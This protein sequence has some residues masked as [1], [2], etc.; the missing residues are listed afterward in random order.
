M[1]KSDKQ[2]QSDNLWE[3]V[4][5]LDSSAA[6]Q[7]KQK[8]YESFPPQKIDEFEHYTI[9]EEL[10]RGRMGI[11][12][13]AKHVQDNKLYALKILPEKVLHD[14]K[15][16]QRFFQEICIHNLLNHENIIRL[17][18]IGVCKETVFIVMEFVAGYDLE[19]MLRKKGPL[20][21]VQALTL[22]VPVISALQYAHSI[23]IIH[24]DMKPANILIEE[25]TQ[26]PKVADF[27]LA[28][29]GSQDSNTPDEAFGTPAY[30]APEQI[31]SSQNVDIR[32]DIYAVGG[33]LYHALYG[34]RPYDQIESPPIL[35]KTKIN[36]D[37]TDLADLV[38]NLSD[39]VL[40]V[41]RRAMSRNPS[42]RYQT[43]EEFLQEAKEALEI[44]KQ[45][46]NTSIKIIGK[47]VEDIHQGPN[48]LAFQPIVGEP[49]M[50]TASRYEVDH[51]LGTF[52][53]EMSNFR[54]T[55]VG[56]II[57][58]EAKTGNCEFSETLLSIT[59]V[60]EAAIKIPESLE[61]KIA[62]TLFSQ[63]L[64]K[65]I[66][67]MLKAGTLN[68]EYK[69]VL[70]DLK[71]L[72]LLRGNSLGKREFLLQ[73]INQGETVLTKKVEELCPITQSTNFNKKIR[74]YLESF[75]DGILKKYEEIFLE[76]LKAC[77]DYDELECY[78]E[79]YATLSPAIIKKYKNLQVIRRVKDLKKALD[80]RP[81]E[82]RSLLDAHLGKKPTPLHELFR[83]WHTTRAEQ[84]LIWSVVD[85]VMN[86]NEL[87][88]HLK[89][90]QE[91]PELKLMA[92]RIYGLVAGFLGVGGQMS[93]QQLK[94][95]LN[96]LPQRQAGKICQLVR[97]KLK[98]E[99]EQR[100]QELF[101]FEGD[102]RKRL[103]SLFSLLR[104]PRYHE[105]IGLYG[106]EVK[107]LSVRLGE[108]RA[109]P[110]N[111]QFDVLK[112]KLPHALLNLFL[113][114][115]EVVDI[116]TKNLG[117]CKA[118]LDHLAEDIIA[119]KPIQA[120][121]EFTEIFKHYAKINF[122]KEDSIYAIDGYELAR[123]IIQYYSSNRQEPLLLPE[124]LQTDIA[125]RIQRV[126]K[127][128]TMKHT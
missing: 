108:L 40:Q 109:Q 116:R 42:A 36:E 96:F 78:L 21:E 88:A 84:N 59:M 126:I 80:T 3:E 98:A 51:V 74:K 44:A 106:Y 71:Y 13:K 118:K 92:S 111:P 55:P 57:Q 68:S 110:A 46:R 14:P 100:I 101:Q 122:A 28:K 119:H 67:A 95:T 103:N 53:H 31:V 65:N 1:D 22:L 124:T 33:I 37:P 45:K 58:E 7:L 4:E 85:R 24:R 61:K 30:M 70:E 73:I 104:N 83:K 90:L 56:K 114:G 12:Y 32:A 79:N 128:D 77:K 16:S 47:S 94:T 43:P 8:C 11:V 20:S 117:E 35:L 38:P 23:H 48:S 89:R 49:L 97:S 54:Q 99:L 50:M 91:K 72:L 82:L 9:V 52:H 125:E 15:A 102:T 120:L 29:F 76:E 69:K 39:K 25:V 127:L 107:D 34:N 60:T 62:G 93:L 115:D 64:L 112:S 121:R 113:Q 81:N 66:T 19:T 26:K 27:G 63:D 75:V 17:H 41:V 123:R 86:L 2:S 87:V 5:F 10:G 18:K 6:K 105:N